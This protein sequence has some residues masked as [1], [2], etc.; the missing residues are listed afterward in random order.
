MLFYG[1][2]ADRV[3]RIIRSPKR[4]ESGVVKNT[5]AVMAPGLNKKKP[6]EVWT[7]YQ[8]K[9]SIKILISAWRYP[10]VSPVG[11]QIPIPADIL[12]ELKEDGIISKL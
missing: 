8:Q 3:K 11:K 10:G 6:S 9:G 1:L 12:A 5:I 4:V 2:T 7:M